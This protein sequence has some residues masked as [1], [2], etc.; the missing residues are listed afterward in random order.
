[1]EGGRWI[2]LLYKSLDVLDGFFVHH[3][4]TKHNHNPH[5]DRIIDEDHLSLLNQFNH[6]EIRGKNIYHDRVVV[7][8]RV[9][10]VHWKV[11]NEAKKTKYTSIDFT[12]RKCIDI[13]TSSRE[14]RLLHSLFGHLIGTDLIRKDHLQINQQIILRSIDL[15]GTILTNTLKKEQSTIEV[16]ISPLVLTSRQNWQWQELIW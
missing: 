12:E 16:R 5:V 6:H 8:Y 9:E 7:Y 15:I 4:E 10:I 13:N 1:M 2:L 14:R 3:W 11:K